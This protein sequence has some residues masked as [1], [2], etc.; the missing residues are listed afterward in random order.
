MKKIAQHYGQRI[1]IT[2]VA[3]I[4]F[5]G[6]ASALSLS[7]QMGLEIGHTDNV[8]L[9]EQRRAGYFIRT[10]PRLMAELEI[11]PDAVLAWETA[12]D[13]RFFPAE[14]LRTLG[15]RHRF[16]SALES[17]WFINEDWEVG[18]RAGLEHQETF[19]PIFSTT[20]IH[21]A[22]VVVASGTQR[23]AYL[24]PSARGYGRLTYGDLAFEAAL[25][26][27]SRSYSTQTFDIL[28]NRYS[29]HF[30]QPSLEANVVYKPDP[31]LTFA[32]QNSF[33]WRAYQQRPSTDVYGLPQA[34]GAAPTAMV[35]GSSHGLTATWRRDKVRLGLVTSLRFEKDRIT[36]GES[37][38]GIK[39][40]FS[41]SLPLATRIRWDTTLSQFWRDFDSFSADYANNPASQPRRR[42]TLLLFTTGIKYLLAESVDLMADV[43]HQTST[44]NFVGISYRETSVRLG[45]SVRL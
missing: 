16:G 4:L 19:P 6:P 37:N 2:G 21:P 13:I 36:G 43:T 42:D 23:E 31:L 14:P 10:T 41:A 44:S 27:L 34:L 8:S 33:D 3:G 30:S 39:V 45:A 35:S 24:A 38:R 29:N 18:A 7:P 17:V 20:E 22:L 26:Y 28:G 11:S 1:L 12:A 32:F 25:A 9:V 40:E 5:C 15:N